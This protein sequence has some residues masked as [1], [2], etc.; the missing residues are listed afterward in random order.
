MIFLTPIFIFYTE[1]SS[2]NTL[3]L[4]TNIFHR[5]KGTPSRCAILKQIYFQRS[6]STDFQSSNV[7]FYKLYTQLYRTR[8]VFCFLIG[9][10]VV[11]VFLIGPIL[12]TI[13]TNLLSSVY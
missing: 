8:T 13:N 11:F 10:I 2:Y 12:K 7:L 4:Y 1:I 5:F 9:P 6:L 3:K